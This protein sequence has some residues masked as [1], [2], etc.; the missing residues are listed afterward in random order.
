VDEHLISYPLAKAAKKLGFAPECVNFYGRVF[1]HLDFDHLYQNP[2]CFSGDFSCFAPTQAQLGAWLR[3][4]HE[5]HVNVQHNYH[6]AWQVKVQDIRGCDSTLRA[7]DELWLA[8]DYG[9][10]EDA[11]AAG[12]ARALE[13]LS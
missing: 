3:R 7:V 1:P 12:L 4:V 11:L 5:L 8:N 6:Y 10:Y 13:Q 2:D 9:S